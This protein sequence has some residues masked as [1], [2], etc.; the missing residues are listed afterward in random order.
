MQ[1][2]PKLVGKKTVAG[3]TIAF[4]VR[5]MLLYAKFIISSC[6]VNVFVEHLGLG[7]H[8]LRTD[9]TNVQQSLFGYL[10]LGDNL[11]RILPALCLIAEGMIAFITR[12][13]SLYLFDKRFDTL[14]QNRISGKTS[15]TVAV[16]CSA[17]YA[18][19]SFA[20]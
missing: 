6:T 3:G 2:Q 13:L 18:K 5:F 14:Q 17:R 20:E 7:I 8:H 10:N 15:H 4:G 16:C 11:A 19:T 12:L 9:K 1:K